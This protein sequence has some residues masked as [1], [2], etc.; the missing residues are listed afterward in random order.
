MAIGII[1]WECLFFILY[2]IIH[3]FLLSNTLRLFNPLYL[4]DYFYYR[5]SLFQTNTDA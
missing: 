1:L 5:K 2:F 4:F 3:V